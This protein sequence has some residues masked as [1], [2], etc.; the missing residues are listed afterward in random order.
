ME[1]ESENLVQEQEKAVTGKSCS[2]EFDSPSGEIFVCEF[3]SL[4]KA[5]YATDGKHSEL[6]KIG[7]EL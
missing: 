3:S 4:E 7:E 6:E 2:I 1:L 5:G